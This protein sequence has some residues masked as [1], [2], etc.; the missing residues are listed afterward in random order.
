VRRL[1]AESLAG[2]DLFQDLAQRSRDS[3]GR[4]AIAVVGSDFQGKPGFWL[5][6]SH[7]DFTSGWLGGIEGDVQ[8]HGCAVLAAGQ[9]TS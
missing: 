6:E 9:R 7:V 5:L 8:D 4:Q 3:M 1:A 2:I